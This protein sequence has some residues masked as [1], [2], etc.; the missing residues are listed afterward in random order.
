MSLR[1]LKKEVRTMIDKDMDLGQ[2]FGVVEEYCQARGARK[3]NE[4]PQKPKTAAAVRVQCRGITR[5]TRQPC[6]A[7]SEPGTK[8]CR[9][10]APK[11]PRVICGSRRR[12]DG[13]PCTARSVPG[14]TRCRWHGGASTGPRTSEGRLRSLAN[15]RQFVNHRTPGSQPSRADSNRA[16]KV[17]RDSLYTHRG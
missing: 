12:R 8:R 10:H 4:Y 13:L 11:G 5:G 16:R 15:L 17:G 6:K 7:L 14:R 3:A 9:W 2:V 1:S